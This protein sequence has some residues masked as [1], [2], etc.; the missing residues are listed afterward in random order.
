MNKPVPREFVERVQE[1]AHSTE[2]ELILDH[3][4]EKYQEGWR[5][6]PPEQADRR[7]HLYRMVQAVEGLKNEIRSIALGE[8]VEAHN[9]GLKNASTWSNI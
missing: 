3:L 1:F 5:T 2:V 7:E 8:I 4:I 6:S 9:R